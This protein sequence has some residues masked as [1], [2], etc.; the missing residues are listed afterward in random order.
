MAKPE[1]V[2][3]L[4][5]VLGA[6]VRRFRTRRDWS[7]QQ[8][9]E[10]MKRLGVDMNR[11]TLAKVEAGSRATSIVEVL[12]LAAALGVPPTSLFIPLGDEPWMRVTPT[13]IMHPGMAWNWLRA[14]QGFAESAQPDWVDFDPAEAYRDFR[15]TP[16]PIWRD[17]ATVIWQYDLLDELTDKADR[18]RL[19]VIWTAR[20]NNPTLGD[21][22]D[23]TTPVEL[24]DA[25]FESA[26]PDEVQAYDAALRKLAQQMVVMHRW[27]MLID[28]ELVADQTVSRMR[29][30]DAD[31]DEIWKSVEGRR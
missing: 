22:G 6:R 31:F 4:E 18:A 9:V 7:Q 21:R 11:V 5:E 15:E 24:T 19:D 29:E 27:R 16:S 26:D 3:P 20:R 30:L 10:E 23:R 13:T 2:P 17:E 1:D 8:L 14:R 25:W 12:T 28:D